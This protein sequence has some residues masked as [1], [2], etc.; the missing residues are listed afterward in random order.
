MILIFYCVCI[1]ICAI[2]CAIGC[3]VGCVQWICVYGCLGRV[4]VW[5]GWM[6]ACECTI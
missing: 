1:Y 4:H 5:V 3:T 2:E 6:C